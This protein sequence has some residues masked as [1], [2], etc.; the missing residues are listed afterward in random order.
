MVSRK[1]IA[2][3]DSS[4]E[5]RNLAEEMVLDASDI[6][7]MGRDALTAV[8]GKNYNMA[9]INNIEGVRGAQYRAVT[10]HAYN[11]HLDTR[12]IDPSKMTEYVESAIS[13]F[14][15]ADGLE[16]P[17]FIMNKGLEYKTAN[18]EGEALEGR[19]TIRE[20]I[21]D[22]IEKTKTILAQENLDPQEKYNAMQSLSI[23]SQIAIMAVDMPEEL[24]ND[25]SKSY[26]SINAELGTT[27]VKVAVRSSAVGEDSDDAAFAG[28]QDTYLMISGEENVALH[29]QRNF[30]SG[31]NIRSLEYRLSQIDKE[32]EEK[33]TSLADALDKFDFDNIAVSV[34]I[35]Q[36]INSGA[37]DGSGKAGTMFSID[38]ASGLEGVV[39]IEANFGVGETVVGGE[40]T[41]DN[42]LVTND[43]KLVVKTLGPKDVMMVNKEGAIGT[44][45]IKTPENKIYEWV[46]NEAEIAELTRMA[47][48]VADHYGRYMDMEFAIDDTG[49][50]LVQAR[51]ETNFNEMR[52]ENPNLIPMRRTEVPESDAKKAEALITGDGA[53]KGAATGTVRY[54]TEITPET[55]KVFKKGDILVAERTDPDFLPLFKLAGAVVANVGGRTSHAA[56]TSRELNIPAVIGVNNLEALKAMDGKQVTVDGTRGTIFDGELRL[57]VA[58]TDIDTAVINKNFQTDTSVGLI[59]AD[60]DGAKS[61]SGLKKVDD[62]KVGLLRAE[63][64]LGAIGVHYKALKA[65]DAGVFD[66][67]LALDANGG[68]KPAIAEI[69][70]KIQ[71]IDDA[72][73]AGMVPE[74]SV[75]EAEEL[76]LEQVKIGQAKFG[77]DYLDQVI[78][79]QS[80]IGTRLLTTGYK[81][82]KEFYIQNLSQQVALFARS[83]DGKDVIY[84]TTDYK[85]NEYEG[86]MGGALY[87]DDEDNPMLGYRGVSR[88]ID[89]WEMEAFNKA[90]QDYGADNLHMMFPFVRKESEMLDTITSARAY[91]SDETDKGLKFYVMAEIPSVAQNPHAF[92]KYVDGFSIG[93]NDLTQGYLMT[94]RDSAKLQATYDEEDPSLVEAT[95]SIIFSAIHEGKEVGYCGMGVSNSEFIAAMVSVAGISSASV[96]PDVYAKTKEGIHNMEA[97]GVTVETLGQWMND[98]K[99]TEMFTAIDKVRA[100]GFFDIPTISTPEEAYTWLLSAKRIANE[101]MLSENA[102]KQ[103]KGRM[104]LKL[105]GQVTEPIVKANV[106]Y[107]AIVDKALNTAGFTSAREYSHVLNSQRMLNERMEELMEVMKRKH[108]KFNHSTTFFKKVKF[109]FNRMKTIQRELSILKTKVDEGTATTEESTEF[110]RLTEL[111]GYMDSIKNDIKYWAD[112]FNIK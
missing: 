64:V 78:K 48:A 40:V 71:R 83:F 103:A 44:E 53:S 101:Q 50:Y 100:R 37:R 36:M 79:T 2:L 55:F 69:E 110:N 59:L 75:T 27:E 11:Q 88:G 16:Q 80:E 42:Y 35:Q 23:A 3:N 39:N 47:K 109:V 102:S 30:A 14:N 33:G 108:G 96:T 26:T 76:L 65:Y 86:L 28:A 84:R 51:P 87:E 95:L 7:K 107:S 31:F 72:F 20:F 90:R 8:G 41:P 24:L 6:A 60:V 106:D 18:N 73:D 19:V 5:S 52:A 49:I 4:V 15:A 67:I 70:A 68:L 111:N 81:T 46:L 56:I 99:T 13:E 12:F 85:S 98:F 29:V 61:L 38:P 94:D 63:F 1:V 45:L 74:E 34:V 92:L 57:E 62:F 93:S 58:G 43:G 17:T 22:R 82:G 32:I 9:I 21:K 77:D 10:A 25:I 89:T 66:K 97:Q 91:L 54:V 105:L 112:V 104:A